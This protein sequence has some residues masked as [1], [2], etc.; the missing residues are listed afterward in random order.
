MLVP[1]NRT[2]TMQALGIDPGRRA[3]TL[4]LGEFAALANAYVPV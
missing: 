2:L 4:S 1:E 3:E